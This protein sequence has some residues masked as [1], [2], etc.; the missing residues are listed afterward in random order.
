MP[1]QVLR[2]ALLGMAAVI[3][4]DAIASLSSVGL[5]FDY[6]YA[7]LGSIALYGVFGYWTGR[8]SSIYFGPLVGA[9]MGLTDA[10]LGWLVSWI[11]GPG[12]LEPGA[13]TPQAWLVVAAQV[14]AVAALCA[15]VGSVVGRY[16][17]KRGRS[18]A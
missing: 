3:A 16:V 5:G 7:A 13:L 18:E 8:D 1:T 2:V 6:R 4:F 10:T 9:F 12:R 17:P 14:I 11:V 15:L